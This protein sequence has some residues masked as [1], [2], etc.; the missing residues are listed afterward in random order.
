MERR[1]SWASAHANGGSNIHPA[2]SANTRTQNI[3]HLRPKKDHQREPVVA[4]SDE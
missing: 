1:T 2:R 3:E 4:L